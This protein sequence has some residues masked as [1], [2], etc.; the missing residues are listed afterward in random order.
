MRK[1]RTAIFVIVALAFA[2]GVDFALPRLITD[3]SIRQIIMLAA[4]NVV[5]ALSLNIIN[6]MAGQFSIG[7][8][9]FISLGAYTSAVLSANMH[10]WLGGGDSTFGKSFLIV[11]TCLLASAIVAA[12][13]GFVVG[14]P[15]LRLRGDYLA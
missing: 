13:F 3:G 15:S 4:C 2:M 8:A 7:H 10:V 6:G 12:V 1:Y 14:L 11:P 9:G 5:V